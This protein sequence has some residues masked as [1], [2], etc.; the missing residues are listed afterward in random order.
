MVLQ[1][2]QYL[3]DIAYARKFNKPSRIYC[4]YLSNIFRGKK[5]SPPTKLLRS[6]FYELPCLYMYAEYHK[7]GNFRCKNIFV[8]NGSYKN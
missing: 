7:S 1:I 4:M 8:V 3:L 6:C 2:L 5:I